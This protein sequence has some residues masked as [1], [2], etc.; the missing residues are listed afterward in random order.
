MVGNHVH[1][2]VFFGFSFIMSQ[3]EIFVNYFGKE[4]IDLYY[5]FTY[6]Y[7]PVDFYAAIDDFR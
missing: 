2:S 1:H 4:E 5:L 3:I 7:Q 6:E